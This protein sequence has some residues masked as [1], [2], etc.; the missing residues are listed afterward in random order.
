MV[1][2]SGDI[3][4]NTYTKIQVILN[5]FVTSQNI[6]RYTNNKELMLLQKSFVFKD[7]LDKILNAIENYYFQRVLNTKSDKYYILQDQVFI[8]MLFYSGMRRNELRTRLIDDVYM[9]NNEI[10]IDVNT[11]GVTDLNKN[12]KKKFKS[13]NAIRHIKT[14]ID[15]ETHKNLIEIFL[16]KRINKKSKNKHLFIDRSIEYID[17]NQYKIY[18]KSKIIK[19]YHLNYFNVIIKNVT[20]RYCT[21]HSLRHSYASYQIANIVKNKKSYNTE[22]IDFSIKIGHNILDTTIQSY[23]HN[24]EFFTI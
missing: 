6:K 7:E 24:L 10:F 5:I 11:R 20:K 4:D 17:G 18:S 23:L 1:V 2:L 3:I 12:Q 9:V 8:L 15:N 16:S 22:L 19:N 14:I 21:L 13:K